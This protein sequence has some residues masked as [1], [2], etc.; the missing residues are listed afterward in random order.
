MLR[1][2]CLQVAPQV[3]DV[4][5]EVGV[6]RLR[7]DQPLNQVG[8]HLETSFELGEVHRRQSRPVRRPGA[9]LPA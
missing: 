3:L 2:L 8:R 1:G 6:V 7:V 4:R 9:T 5:H